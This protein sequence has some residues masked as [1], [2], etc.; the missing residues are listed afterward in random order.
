MPAEYQG[1][2]KKM[3]K[4]KIE[5]DAAVDATA[6]SKVDLHRRAEELVRQKPVHS[7][8]DM[9]DFS[10]ETV[11]LLQHELQVHQIELEMQ[12]EELR[13]SQKDLEAS[14]ARYFELYN[15][16]PVGY[17]TINEKGRILEAN[18]TFATMICVENRMIIG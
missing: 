17:L 6:L 1:G 12:N 4:K 13:R 11:D 18:L 5:C 9:P 2:P 7:Q 16:A 10:I 3:T 8:K 15:L 14:R